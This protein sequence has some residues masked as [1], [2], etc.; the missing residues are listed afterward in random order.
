MEIMFG[1]GLLLFGVISMLVGI[2][3]AK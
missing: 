1:T 3:E 2:V